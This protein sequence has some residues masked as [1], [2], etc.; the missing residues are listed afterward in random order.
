MVK[1]YDQK[2][3][4]RVRDILYF[5]N[6]YE[7]ALDLLLRSLWKWLNET[8]SSLLPRISY[9][10]HHILDI[11]SGKGGSHLLST[12]TRCRDIWRNFI[13]IFF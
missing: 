3:T 7:G 4:V 8:Y 1:Y 10:T 2:L 12:S 13:R 9:I 6:R 5:Y 11:I